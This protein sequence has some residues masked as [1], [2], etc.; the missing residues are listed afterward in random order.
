MQQ[1]S[2][3][4]GAFSSTASFGKEQHVICHCW[5]GCDGARHACLRRRLPLGHDE[6]VIT[7]WAP[8][9][10]QTD[11][12]LSSSVATMTCTSNSK[13]CKAARHTQPAWRAGCQCSQHI[14]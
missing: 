12:I 5:E 14:V 2:S 8:A 13:P 3:A 6:L 10:R 7:T 11:A 1:G 9:A 4:T